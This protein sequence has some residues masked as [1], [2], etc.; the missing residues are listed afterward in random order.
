MSGDERATVA[1]GPLLSAGR[2]AVLFAVRRFDECTAED[3]A[4]SLEM[5]VSGARQHLS[6]LVESGLIGFVEEPRP[7]GQRGRHR[8]RYHTTEL[9]DGV[10]PKAYDVL[11]NDLLGALAEESPDAV[12]R[13]FAKRRQ[14]RIATAERRLEGKRTLGA[15]VSELA[16]IL[17][18]DGYLATSESR[19]RTHRIVEHNCAIAAVARR[20]GQACTSEIEFIRAVLPEARVERV[21]HLHDGARHCAYEIT[22]GPANRS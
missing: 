3:I 10:F 4:E 11:A 21:R 20:Y 1:V 14:S 6:A 18:D 8:L 13:V 17:D 22:E 2:R 12:E 16:R 5:T 19:G 9:A 7:P 15:K